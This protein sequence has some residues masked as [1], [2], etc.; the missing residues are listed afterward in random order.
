MGNSIFLRGFEIEDALLINK[1][2]NDFEIQ[3]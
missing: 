3:K 1:W 2:R